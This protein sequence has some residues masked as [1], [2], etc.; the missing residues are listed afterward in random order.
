[1]LVFAIILILVLWL[2][3]I[4]YLEKIY[5]MI[6]VNEVEKAVNEV[7]EIIENTDYAEISKN[8]ES[9]DY[10]EISKAIGNTDYTENEKLQEEIDTVKDKLRTTASKYEICICVVNSSGQAVFS[11]EN[12]FGCII[13]M[14]SANEAASYYER[15]VENGG[16]IVFSS[17]EEM[18]KRDLDIREDK[19]L[20]RFHQK[21]EKVSDEALRVSYDTATIDASGDM[22]MQSPGNTMQMPQPEIGRPIEENLVKVMQKG[23]ESMVCSSIVKV[24]GEECMILVD[25]R[26]TPVDATVNTLRFELIVI[27]VVL[28]LLALGLAYL[29]S[30]AVSKPIIS[31]NESAKQLA[32]GNYDAVFNYGGYREINE[33]SDTLNYTSKELAKTEQYQQELIANV[34]HDLRTP[35]TMI[36]AYSEV[37]RDLPGENTPENVQVIIEEAKRLTNLVNDMLDISKLQKGKLEKEAKIYNLTESINRIMERYGKLKTQDGYDIR[38]EYDTDVFVEADEF[39]IYQV[40]YNLINNAINYTGEDKKVTVKQ[41]IKENIVRIEITDTGDGIPKDELSN[42]WQRYYKASSSH[43]RAVKGTGLGLSIVRKILKLHEA[44][45]GVESEEGKGSIF[46]FELERCQIEQR[47]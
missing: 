26:L 47:M 3:Q 14:L 16:N 37:M 21:E 31:I 33:L 40:L 4:V 28:L 17:D 2:C 25:S 7:S 10:A 41:I 27:S 22:H 6:K 8:I 15:T 11:V 39:K 45:F 23:R 18:K 32:K 5:K 36:T 38:F 12:S 1:M 34:S 9:A 20:Q 43:K 30:R 35:L 46:W 13:H 42:V 29:I 19:Q 24:N 44:E